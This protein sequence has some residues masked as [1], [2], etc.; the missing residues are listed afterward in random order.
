MVSAVQKSNFPIP[1]KSQL[2]LTF[3]GS[4]RSS[5]FYMRECHEN[6]RNIMDGLEVEG[7]Q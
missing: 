4:D 7:M 1:T 5:V 2:R 6:F 3:R